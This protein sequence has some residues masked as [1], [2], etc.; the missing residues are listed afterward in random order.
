MFATQSSDRATSRKE[1]IMATQT[2]WTTRHSVRFFRTTVTASLLKRSSAILKG[3]VLGLLTVGLMYGLPSE[4][5]GSERD[6]LPQNTGIFELDVECDE[7][8]AHISLHHKIDGTQI[9]IGTVEP[10]GGTSHTTT[11]LLRSNIR[12][13]IGK[14]LLIGEGL[15]PRGSRSDSAQHE[16][17]ACLGLT[18]P[19]PHARSVHCSG[20]TCVCYPDQ[21]TDCD[22][23][24]RICSAT[25]GTSGHNICT[26]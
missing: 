21:H 4:S 7:G 15:L 2:R 24:K 13:A 22:I 1:P 11:P 14:E 3:T 9:D 20:K 10:Q 6:S 25:G 12:R 8:V 16:I 17:T 23:F 19:D 26:W 5:W 18:A